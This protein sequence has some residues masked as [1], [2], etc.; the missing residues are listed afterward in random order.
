MIK[1]KA[2]RNN[3]G[4]V[5]VFSKGCLKKRNSVFS[6]RLEMW[7]RGVGVVSAIIRNKKR[8]S[9][10][11]QYSTGSIVINPHTHGTK[12]G[13]FIFSS[14]LPHKFWCNFKTNCVVLLRFLLKFSIISNIVIGGVS[15]YATAA[16]T[17]CQIL[18]LFIEYNLVKVMLP[19]K[20]IKIFTG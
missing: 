18:E 7:N 15:K 11:I 20:Q 12:L 17:Y 16:G 5:T 3:S 13:Q 6:T 9:A 8:L 4:V 1:N 14:I 19:S 10:V 2:G